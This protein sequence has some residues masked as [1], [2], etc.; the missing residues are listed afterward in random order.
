MDKRIIRTKQ[1][2]KYSLLELLTSKNI[3]DITVSELCKIAKINRTTFYKYYTDVNDVM[4]KTEEELTIELKKEISNIS[5]N[6]LLSFTN[7]IVNVI[8]KDKNTYV[9]LLSSNGD[10]NFLRSILQLVYKESIEEWTKLLRKASSEDIEKIYNFI[11]DGTI[12]VIENWI[13]NKCKDE[14]NNISI[15]INKICMSGLSSFI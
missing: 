3:H 9:P 10:H 2:L 14:T 7:H 13:K 1:R 15:F 12:G 11:V 4:F 6:Y 5:R 8:S